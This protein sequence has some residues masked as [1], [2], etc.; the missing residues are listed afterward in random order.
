MKGGRLRCD[1]EAFFS[2]CS[3]LRSSLGDRPHTPALDDVG[4]VQ[5]RFGSAAGGSPFRTSAHGLLTLRVS[6]RQAASTPSTFPPTNPRIR[7][8]SV[9][10]IAHCASISGRKCEHL[11]LST[12]LLTAFA[13]AHTALYATSGIGSTSCADT[14]CFTLRKPNA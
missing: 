12:L 1:S 2:R 10:A 3:S 8:L 7:L 14:R 11:R 13:R 6:R 4:S 9:T 5:D